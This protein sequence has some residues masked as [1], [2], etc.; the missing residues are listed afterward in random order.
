M[1][2]QIITS[3]GIAL[4]YLDYNQEPSL[5]PLLLLHGLTANAHA[6]D[7]LILQGLHKK[8][9][10]LAPDLRGR[11][12]SG[13]P[14][15][16][17]RFEDHAQDL[18]G[19]LD[20][21][22][23]DEVTICGHSYGGYLGVYLAVHYPERV[24]RLVIMDAA[25]AMNSRLPEMLLPAL[26]RLGKTFPSYEAY[27]EQMKAA[28]HNTFWEPAMEDYYRADVIRNEDGSVTT[29]SS[30]A[31]IIEIS[32]GTAAEPWPDLFPAIKQPVSLLHATDPYALDEPLLPLENAEATVALI[33]DCIYVPI[34][35][36]HQTMLYGPG[37][38]AIVAA[39]AGS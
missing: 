29:Q 13:K 35:G 37:A 17:Y 5:P 15:S 20:Q 1:Q 33:P 11:G 16:G 8:F 21:L 25:I 19:L 34:P 3:N 24:Q 30:L 31:H 9:R 12:L 6:F 39:I 4:H 14:E 36:N 18:L 10:V 2:D 26:S 7:G 22:Q 32:K 28:P 23:I 38:A 27:L